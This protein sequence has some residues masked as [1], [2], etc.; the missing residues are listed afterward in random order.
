MIKAFAFEHFLFKNYTFHLLQKL[1]M[2]IHLQ[3][4]D[5]DINM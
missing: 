2:I 4:E 1:K 5:P 3:K